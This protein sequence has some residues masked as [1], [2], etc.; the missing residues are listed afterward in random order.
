MSQ[1]NSVRKEQNSKDL[2]LRF[3]QL[4][5]LISKIEEPQAKIVSMNPNKTIVEGKS[6][7][8]YFFKYEN[9]KY[10]EIKKENSIIEFPVDKKKN[11]PKTSKKKLKTKKGKI[12]SPN[13][14]KILAPAVISLGIGFSALTLTRTITEKQNSNLTI[15][16]LEE[17][18]LEKSKFAIPKKEEENQTTAD[19]QITEFCIQDTNVMVKPKENLQKRIETDTVLGTEICYYANRYGIPKSI[20]AALITQERPD[21]IFENVGQLTRNICGEKINIPIICKSEEEYINRI[22]EEK[23]YIVRDMPERESFE[24]IS[25]Y[26]AALKRYQEQLEE[27]KELETQ[28]YNIYYFADLMKNNNQ[29]IHIAM[30]YLAYCTYKCDLNVHQGIRA[31]NG[32][33]S[34]S[35]KASDDDLVRGTLEIGDPYYNEH[36]FA[37]LYPEEI[38]DII[39]KLQDPETKEFIAVSMGFNN[40]IE[41]SEQNAKE[42]NGHHL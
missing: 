33:Y 27:S 8:C 3:K 9:D 20:A 42:E 28:G 26:K 23:I 18:E 31:Y 25:S 10:I 41:M 24:E 13:A 36:V 29:N 12:I 30:A 4:K 5:E 14:R 7:N 38:E 15:E 37:Y 11:V 34:L 40:I 21:D 6:G 39:W 16:T 1:Q 2:Q 17:F 35:K 19:P 32:G 22:Q